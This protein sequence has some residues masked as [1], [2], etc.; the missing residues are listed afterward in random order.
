MLSVLTATGARDSV[1]I[2]EVTRH[3]RRQARYLLGPAFGLCLSGYFI[4][5]LVEGDRGLGA[6][7][8]LTHEIRDAK[9]LA[10]DVRAQRET[11]EQRAALLRPEHL[12]PDMLDEQARS[13]LNMVAPGEIVILR[14][15]AKK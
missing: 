7:L 13:S 1:G 3:L 2:M 14:P 9:A 6:W 15:G 5:H 12:D 10:A 4:Y 11:A 8:R